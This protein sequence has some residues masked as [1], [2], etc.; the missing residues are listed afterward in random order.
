MC[1]A[2]IPQLDSQKDPFVFTA[3]TINLKALMVR[4][5]P[6]KENS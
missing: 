2:K 1:L 6:P 4:N 5:W 3:T